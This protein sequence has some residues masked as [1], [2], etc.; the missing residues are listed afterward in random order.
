MTS[1]LPTDILEQRAASERQRLHDSVA[2]LRVT[3]KD[4]LNLRRNA[5]DYARQHLS[6]SAALAALLGLAF[7]WAIG[8]IFT[9]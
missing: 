6:G 4:K 9:S 5:E 3:M 1:G 2:E 8:G 7:G